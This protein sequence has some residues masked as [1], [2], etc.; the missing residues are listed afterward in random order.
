MIEGELYVLADSPKC[1]FAYKGEFGLTIYYYACV[2][3]S[4]QVRIPGI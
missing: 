3:S 2:N 4:N 1:V